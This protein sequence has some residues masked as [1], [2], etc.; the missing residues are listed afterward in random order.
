MM[1]LL[2]DITTETGMASPSRAQVTTSPMITTPATAHAQHFNTDDFIMGPDTCGFTSGTRITCTNPSDYCQNIGNYRGCCEG[3]ID[4]CSA[5]VYT[6]CQ[7]GLDNA[8]QAHVLYC[9]H[10]TLLHHRRQPGQHLHQCRVRDQRRLWA[11]IPLSAR[12]DAHDVGGSAP[13]EYHD[14]VLF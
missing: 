5:T 7:E 1:P 4:Q 10:D 9:L 13:E 12:A 14:A 8:Y 2:R 3:A 6:T 11:A